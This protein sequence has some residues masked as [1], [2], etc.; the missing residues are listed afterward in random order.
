MEGRRHWGLEFPGSFCSGFQFLQSFMCSVIRVPAKQDC[1][2]MLSLKREADPWH[3]ILAGGE[4]KRDFW[5]SFI[6]SNLSRGR[7]ELGE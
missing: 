2:L 4:Q 5:N 3:Q 6:C 7:V 1:V